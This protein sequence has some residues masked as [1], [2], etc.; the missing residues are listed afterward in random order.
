M[1]PQTIGSIFKSQFVEPVYDKIRRQL[2]IEDVFRL[3]RL[4]GIPK[5]ATKH[6]HNN[7]FDSLLDAD[8]DLLIAHRDAL[9]AEG[10][11]KGLPSNSILGIAHTI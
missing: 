4:L 9:M 7:V 2:L 8:Y 1:E 11:R 3:Y 6:W 10:V 5:K